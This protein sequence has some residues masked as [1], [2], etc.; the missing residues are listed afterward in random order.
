MTETRICCGTEMKR[1]EGRLEQSGQTHLPTIVW[2][3]ETCNTQ[4]W[5]AARNVPWQ[6]T[7]VVDPLTKQDLS[8]PRKP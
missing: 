2:T 4:H 1:S 5:D 3:C 8:T 6:T 7:K